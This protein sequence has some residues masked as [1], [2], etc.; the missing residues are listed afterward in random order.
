MKDFWNAD[1]GD[2]VLG[3]RGVVCLEWSCRRCANSGV[4]CYRGFLSLPPGTELEEEKP[5]SRI[6]VLCENRK[7]ASRSKDAL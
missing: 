2:V 1:V 7:V 6:E 5:S 3:V 4:G